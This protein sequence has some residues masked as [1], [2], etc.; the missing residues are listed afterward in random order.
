ME[1]TEFPDYRILFKYTSRSRPA[2]FKRGLLSIID[3]CDSQNYRILCSLDEDDRTLPTYQTEI[4]SCNNPNILVVTGT[5]K[6]KVDAINRDLPEYSENWDILINMSDDML[7]M[8]KGFDQIIRRDFFEAFPDLDGFVHYP[9]KNA[10]PLLAT[11]SIFGKPYYSRFGYIYHPEYTSL[12]C[13]NEA[14][15]VAK[16]LNRYK[17][18]ERSLF[19]H[20]HPAYRKSNSDEQYRL[21]ESFFQVDNLIF[22]K[23][24]RNNFDLGK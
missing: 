6:N 3:N 22:R 10:G 7:F 9:D 15:E 12:W 19:D 16:K 1:S 8:Q 24:Q 4:S 17:Y 23:R 11:M 13:D 21:T 5:S 14:M 2:Q 20:L 18:F